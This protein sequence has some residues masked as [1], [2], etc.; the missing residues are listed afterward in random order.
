MHFT[1]DYYGRSDR[2]AIPAWKNEMAE[3]T[4][5]YWLAFNGLSA[6]SRVTTPALF[7]HADGCVFPDNVRQVHANV[8]GPKELVWAEGNQIDFYDQPGLVEPAVGAAVRWFD[9]TLRS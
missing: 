4:W 5:V 2:G 6:A 3:V 8:R 7:V 1:L 9:S